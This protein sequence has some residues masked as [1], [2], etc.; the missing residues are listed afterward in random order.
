[1]QAL[2]KEAGVE[3]KYFSA[4]RNMQSPHRANESM[5]KQLYAVIFPKREKRKKGIDIGNSL[6][7]YGLGNPFTVNIY[8]S[9]KNL[10]V[11]DIR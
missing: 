11:S 2:I 6:V 7:E 5:T 1:M 9:W 8:G 10:W 4:R 3:C